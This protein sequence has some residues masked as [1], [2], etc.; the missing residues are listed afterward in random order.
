MNLLQKNQTWELVAL[1]K[2]KKAISC[3]WGYKKKEALSSGEPK[4]YKARLIAKGFSQKEGTN[5]NEIFSPVVKHCSIRILHAMAAIWDLELEQLDVKTI[6]LHD[7]LDDEIYIVQPEG[8]VQQD[9]E[10]MVCKL[11]KSLYRLKAGFTL[12]V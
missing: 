2:N 12:V 10:K 9:S 1:P 11:K 5:L 8:F 6:F 4:K 7:N 3:K